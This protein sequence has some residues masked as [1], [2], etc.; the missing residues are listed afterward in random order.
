M[1]GGGEQ[2]RLPLPQPPVA[3]S[4]PP[5]PRPPRAA[6]W[7]LPW[8]CCVGGP[9]GARLWGT[10]GSSG[11]TAREGAPCRFGQTGSAA[12]KGSFIIITVIII[13]IIVII[14]F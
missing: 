6:L 14:F 8:S 11:G 3:P 2:C 7:V 10:T 5:L 12:R 4:R 1:Q 9:L 13:I